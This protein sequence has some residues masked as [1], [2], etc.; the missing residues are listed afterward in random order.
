MVDVLRKKAPLKF[1]VG[2]ENGFLEIFSTRIDLGPVTQHIKGT[3]D[4][5][6]SEVENWLENAK[7][8]DALKVH[9][10]KVEVIEQYED[11]PKPK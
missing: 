3:W 4:I 8:D 7:E 1:T 10:V 11:W 9:L 6:L 2:I 5:Q